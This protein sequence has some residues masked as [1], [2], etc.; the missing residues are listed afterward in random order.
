MMCDG[1][2]KDLVHRFQFFAQDI[3]VKIHLSIVFRLLI[4]RHLKSFIFFLTLQ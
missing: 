2:L 4:L 3:H 1:M